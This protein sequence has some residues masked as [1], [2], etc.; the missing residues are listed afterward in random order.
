MQDTGSVFQAFAG[1]NTQAVPGEPS[2][3]GGEVFMVKSV[4]KPLVAIAAMLAASVALADK[5]H[6]VTGTVVSV[7]TSAHT[8]TLKGA[9]GKTN[10]APVEGD[11]LKSLGGLKAG[12]QVTVTCRDNDM[13]EHQAVTAIKPVKKSGY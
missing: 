5:M 12:E 8:M 2:S 3:Q 10:T 1:G 6:D 7:D 11:A 4:I 13:G 9:D